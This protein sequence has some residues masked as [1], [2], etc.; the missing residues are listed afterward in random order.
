MSLAL[1]MLLLRLLHLVAFALHCNAHYTV[2]QDF[3]HVEKCLIILY[4]VQIQLQLKEHENMYKII[5]K[6][7]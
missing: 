1:T 5:N 6:N 7:T 2:Q 3:E 4:R